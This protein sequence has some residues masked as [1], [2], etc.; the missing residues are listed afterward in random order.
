M[1]EDYP[2]ESVLDVCVSVC[3]VTIQYNRADDGEGI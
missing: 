3:V 1:G 2:A